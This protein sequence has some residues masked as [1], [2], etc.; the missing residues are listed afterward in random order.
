MAPERQQRGRRAPTGRQFRTTG[1][2]AAAV[3]VRAAGAG[4]GAAAY[5]LLRVD[6]GIPRRLAGVGGAEGT[7]AAAGADRRRLN[8]GAL[9]AA[10]SGCPFPSFRESVGARARRFRVA[11]LGSLCVLGVWGPKEEEAKKISQVMG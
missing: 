2:A 9:A 10:R 7:A 6:D 1:A 4:A 11:S 8:G 5:P 3:E